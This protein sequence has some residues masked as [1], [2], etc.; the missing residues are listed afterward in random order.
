MYVCMHACLHACMHACM[1]LSTLVCIYVCTDVGMYNLVCMM[2]NLTVI[3]SMIFMFIR[4]SLS[5]TS[6]MNAPDHL[7]LF[8]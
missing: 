3:W 7:M 8:P 1:Y 4:K 6:L 2:C 5:T